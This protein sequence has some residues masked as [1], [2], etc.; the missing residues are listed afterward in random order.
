MIALCEPTRCPNACITT[1]HRPAWARASDDAK[2]LLKEKRLSGLQ[3]TAL[4]QDIR[5]IEAVLDGAVKS[6][7]PIG[8]CDLHGSDDVP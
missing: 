1:R 5:R 4:T 7:A 2:A 8:R 6:A 3:R